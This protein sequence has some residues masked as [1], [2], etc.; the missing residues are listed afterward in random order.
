M[1]LSKDQSL[2]LYGTEAYT[3]WGEAEAKA[4]AA[5]K[6]VSTPTGGYSTGT[7]ALP[8]FSFDQAAAEKA[9]MEQLRPYYEKLLSIYNGDVGL[10]KKRMEEDYARGLR[11][12]QDATQTGLGDIAATQAERDRKFKLA[13]GDLDQEMNAR[14]LTN[15]GIKT[16]NVANAK[17]DEAYQQQLL[18]NQ[19]RDLTTAEKQYVEGANVDR[20]RFLEDKGLQPVTG[21]PGFMSE[22]DKKKFDLAQQFEKDTG[23]KVENAFNKAQVYHQTASQPLVTATPKNYTDVL[24]SSLKMLGLPTTG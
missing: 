22:T 20:T 21:V 2:A 18:K 5:A 14:G 19:A 24:N 8:K 17:A 1:A 3:G 16:T 4:D 9:A 10:A 12:K 11:Y 7:T 15:S 23:T 6:G 13:L